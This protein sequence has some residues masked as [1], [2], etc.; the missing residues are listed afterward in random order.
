M[1]K[2]VY[3]ALRKIAAEPEVKESEPE[4]L[5]NPIDYWHERNRAGRADAV[6]RD[7]AKLP[8][9]PAANYPAQA[10]YHLPSRPEFYATLR[11]EVARHI[12]WNLMGLAPGSDEYNQAMKYF[13]DRG[14]TNMYNYLRPS[15]P[16]PNP[17]VPEILKDR[18]DEVKSLGNTIGSNNYGK[19]Y[20]GNA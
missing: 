3:N 14:K 11:P 17:A 10:I 2:R 6:L 9:L 16:R 7:K 4:V 1:N 12:A 20:S 5:F 15:N 19:K 8:S 13:I 18:E